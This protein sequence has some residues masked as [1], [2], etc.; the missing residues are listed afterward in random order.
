MP[1]LR[2][3]CAAVAIALTGCASAVLIP[4]D[5]RISIARDLEGRALYLRG[6][7]HVLPFFGDRARRL[8]S[9]LPPDSVELLD[10]TSGKPILPGPPE[11]LLELGTRVR[12]EKVEFPTSLAM[13]RR[14]L[15][16]PRPNPWVFFTVVGQPGERPYV[17]VLRPG[18]KTRDEFL[19]VFGQV[20]VERNPEDALARYPSDVR[21]AL[22]QKRLLR[23]MDGD[24]AKLAWGP[25]ERIH[26]EYV[27]GIKLETWTWPL[28]KRSAT[29]R[30][31]RLSEAVPALE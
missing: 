22:R 7:L 16:S 15:Y 2:P 5:Q 6:S 31:G 14:P 17:A 19:A 20:F 26:Q 25:P 12:I 21:A 9:Q 23:G 13:A 8:V 29:F 24:A 11:G 28:Q 3:L 1:L 4:D 27:G 30:D 18:I 10:D